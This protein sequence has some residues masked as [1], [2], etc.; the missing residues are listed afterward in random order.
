MEIKMHASRARHT[1]N[2][3]LRKISIPDDMSKKSIF[4]LSIRFV[5]ILGG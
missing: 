5:I 2:Y 4:F 3:E 1:R